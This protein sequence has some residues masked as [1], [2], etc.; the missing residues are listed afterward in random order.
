MTVTATVSKN[1]YKCGTLDVGGAPYRCLA[2]SDQSA[3]NAAG[4]PDRDPLKPMGDLP[5]GTYTC[6]L[7]VVEQPK[8]SYGPNPVIHLTP[9]GG[10]AMVAAKDGRDGLLI[11]GG[12]PTVDGCGLRPTHGCLRLSDDDQAEVIAVV[13][14]GSLVTLVVREVD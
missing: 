11:H 1:R 5:T 10:D 7:G 13:D 3:A 2:R 12:D 6:T 14:W 4:N 9:T 8:R